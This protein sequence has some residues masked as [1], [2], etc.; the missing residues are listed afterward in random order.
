MEDKESTSA[1]ELS[2]KEISH[3]LDAMVYYYVSGNC[4]GE[5]HYSLYSKVFQGYRDIAA[6]EAREEITR[7]EKSQKWWERWL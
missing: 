2:N 5:V 6:Q 7:E 3:I 1:V 4:T